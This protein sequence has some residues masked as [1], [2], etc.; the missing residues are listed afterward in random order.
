MLA[1]AP[2]FTGP[3]VQS[4][5]AQLMTDRPKPLSLLRDTVPAHVEAALDKALAKVPA[6]RFAT[7]SDFA[8]ALQK[9][10]LVPLPADGRARASGRPEGVGVP[11]RW[12]AALLGSGAAVGALGMWLVAGGIRQ[13]S[14]P[15]AP[16]ARFSFDVGRLAQTVENNIAVSPNGSIIAYV[17]EDSNQ[18]TALF[19]RFLNRTEV[20]RVSGTERAVQPFFSPEGT[21]LGFHQDGKLRTVSVVGGEISTVCDAPGARGAF[22]AE[23]NVIVFSATRNGRGSLFRVSDAGGEPELLLTP[24]P[25]ELVDFNSPEVLP[26]G[27]TVLFVRWS[28]SSGG[29][30]AALS[31]EDRQVTELGQRGERP[32]Y[33]DPGYVVMFDGGFKARP[34][35]VARMRFTSLA[36]PVVTGARSQVISDRS[37]LDVSRSGTVAFLGGP[38][39]GRELVLVD[40][41]GGAAV[42]PLEPNFYGTPRFSPDGRRIVFVVAYPRTN[43]SDLWVYDTGLRTSS[44]LTLDSASQSPEWSPDGRRVIYAR[45]AGGTPEDWNLHSMPADNSG[46]PELL[47]SRPSAQWQGLLTPDRKTLI[48][49]ESG[50]STQADIWATPVDT[51]NAAHA[52]AATT[53][54]ESAIALSPE[55]RWLAYHSD[56]SGRRE[57]YIRSIT[58][59]G[60]RYQ[61]GQGGA[62]PRWGSGGR[63]LYFWSGD[64]LY[65]V[66]I[67]RGETLEI[68]SARALFGGRFAGLANFPYQSYD[69][70]ADG[71]RFV[72]IRDRPDDRRRIEVV[73]NWFDG[74]SHA[75]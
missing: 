10:G 37:T 47:L 36:R 19:L 45:K 40:R 39:P 27:R 26:D 8:A 50:V 16:V 42:L 58:G 30:L 33:V 72:F 21:R 65:A 4:V 13:R 57:V 67:T 49:W 54:W 15:A 46:P 18:T 55:G 64:S 25:D 31:L 43:A 41:A 61:V 75:R 11:K 56:E 66:P 70:R 48:F 53:G 20:T 5:L 35:D 60:G 38:S 69:V 14:E 32:R 2:P 34:F 24:G 62:Q 68:G 44:R 7:A 9:T 59:S 74:L 17:V 3:T 6:D 12:A 52:L 63:E 71:Q 29:G 28:P 1:G 23:G 73:L 22:W 51:S